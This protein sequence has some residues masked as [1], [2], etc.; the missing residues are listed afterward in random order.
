[1]GKDKEK[2][3]I[4]SEE[5]DSSID[6]FAL[7]ITFVLV[8]FFE[9]YFKIFGNRMVEIV[10]AIGLLLFGIFGTLIEIG[11][12]S[13]D[14]IK[15]GDDLVTGLFL[16]A[17]SVFIIFKFNKVILNIIMFIVLA[18]GIFGA[19]KG[20]IEIL[21]SL[22]IKRRKTENKKVEVMQIVVAATEVV[23][24]AVAII[25]LVNEVSA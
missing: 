15:G 12:I 9:V 2:K 18:F 21:Y 4:F 7:G 11:K 24:L 6:G 1:M 20:V 16:A 25:Q 5:I 22:K 10:L 8:A 3:V 14:N 13:T 23:A 19:M 17:P